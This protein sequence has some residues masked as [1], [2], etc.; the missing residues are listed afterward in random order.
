M[1]RG[2]MRH[3][4]LVLFI[5]A[6]TS[7]GGSSAEQQLLTNFFRASRVR[8]NATLSNLATVEFNPRISGTVQDFE[9]TNIGAEQRR[10]LQIQVV[11]HVRI[12]RRDSALSCDA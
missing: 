5:L 4:L 3:P 12:M 10:T 9:V 6:V 11:R 2:T 7:C 8:D 1:L